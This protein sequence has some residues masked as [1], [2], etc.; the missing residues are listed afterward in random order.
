MI[1]YQ[2]YSRVWPKIE[3]D[4]FLI[5]SQY[6]PVSLHKPYQHISLHRSYCTS[7]LCCKYHLCRAT[8]FFM[9]FHRY[10]DTF[11][12]A[13]ASKYSFLPIAL[14][15]FDL[16]YLHLLSEYHDSDLHN[17]N[18]FII[19]LLKCSRVATWSPHDLIQSLHVMSGMN[20][21][22]VA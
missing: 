9:Q 4:Y 21:M 13:V 1:K 16:Q 10:S 18:L 8:A 11:H 6:I 19:T 12:E 22:K 15:T 20:L 3:C 5:K 14:I 2:S 17:T 7:W